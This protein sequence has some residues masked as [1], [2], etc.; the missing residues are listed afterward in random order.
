MGNFGDVW[1]WGA[2]RW[3]SP[4]LGRWNGC[5]G[6]GGSLHGLLS[7]RQAV[8]SLL[9]GVRLA[10][11]RRF[12]RPSGMTICLARRAPATPLC[13]PPP[14]ASRRRVHQLMPRS[15]SRSSACSRTCRSPCPRPSS[16]SMQP[17]QLLELPRQRRRSRCCPRRSCH[18]G[19]RSV[20]VIRC[21]AVP[22]LLR[23]A[24]GPKAYLILWV[25]VPVIVLVGCVIDLRHAVANQWS[26]PP[27][28]QVYHGSLGW[29]IT[30]LP[31]RLGDHRE[32]VGHRLHLGDP[33]R[34]LPCVPIPLRLRLFT[35]RDALCRPCLSAVEHLLHTRR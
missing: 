12:P 34:H 21:P 23:R 5:L 2:W 31:P 11:Q 17:R 9:T 19:P 27:L 35:F 13:L 25:D 7:P 32:L 6:D 15:R 10:L 28:I 4:W 22:G 33:E 1:W 3:R 20:V 18:A 26:V 24:F 30:E 14:S 16:G 8:C 29:M